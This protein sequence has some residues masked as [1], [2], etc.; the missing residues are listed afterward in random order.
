MARIEAHLGHLLHGDSS[1]VGG[2]AV[3]TVP[4][5]SVAHAERRLHQLMSP[6]RDQEERATTS[7]RPAVSVQSCVE[8]GYSVV[9]VQ[10]RYRP[11]LLL[12]AVCTLT[13]MDYVFAPLL[14]PLAAA[15]A[16]AAASLPSTSE[17]VAQM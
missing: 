16:A 9:T 3:A 13:D 7:P 6:D 17:E 10:C 5:A 1:S 8:R 12:D 11:K 14:L 4:A 2:S 15:A